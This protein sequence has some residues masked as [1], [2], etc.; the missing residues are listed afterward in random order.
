[1]TIAG[2]I[3][4]IR[5]LACWLQFDSL[6][7]GAVGIA[8]WAGVKLKGPVGNRPFSRQAPIG[9]VGPASV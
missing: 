8:G 3:E 1:M 4:T 9:E 5:W 7:D 6:V 2:F